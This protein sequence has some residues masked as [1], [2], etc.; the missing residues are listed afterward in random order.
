MNKFNPQVVIHTAAWVDVDGCQVNPGKAKESNETL[1]KLVV[2]A[3]P[4]KAKI[5]YISTEQ[6]FSGEKP[7]ASE[8]GPTRPI[9][10][11]G[12][13]KLEGLNGSRKI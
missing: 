5:I 9:N 11:Y 6:V 10:V 12:S 13:T 2:N 4:K 8:S 7:Y 1:T 3:S